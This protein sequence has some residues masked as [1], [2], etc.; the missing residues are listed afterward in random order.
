MR[1]YCYSVLA[2]LAVCRALAGEA[3]TNEWGPVTN[4]AQ[5]AISIIPPGSFTV[6]SFRVG[7]T[8]NPPMPTGAKTGKNEVKAGEHFSLLVRIRNLS[9]NVTLNF[10]NA[11]Q[12]NIGLGVG[13]ACVVISPSGK[14]VSPNYSIGGGSGHFATEGPNQ[15]TQFEFA[16]SGLC[17]LK[18]IG[19]Y[20]ITAR[21]STSARHK[22]EKEFVLTS[23]TLRV[24]VVP[25]K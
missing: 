19:T 17:K 25:D 24:S 13:L 14:D 15:T 10:Y 21:K 5:L 23:N 20:K 18:E 6:R 1:A 16:L 4:N 12:P 22:G 2:L 3:T 9:T 8:N 7:D 11:F